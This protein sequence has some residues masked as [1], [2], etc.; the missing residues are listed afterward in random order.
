MRGTTLRES[1]IRILDRLHPKKIVIV[2]SAPQIRYPDYYGIDMSHLSE[3]IAFRAAIELRRDRGE[4]H[5]IKDVYDKCIAQRNLPKTSMKNYVK[6]IYEGFSDE[7]ISR[8]IVE[9]LRPS[10][11]NTD[12]EIV[13][14]TIDDLHRAI[15]NHTGDWYFS[16]DY[17]TPAGVKRV[18]EAFVEYAEEEFGW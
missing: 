11:V 6:E 14:Q 12:I 3:F 2:S 1:V 15:P 17:P 4:L 7:D 5:I 9:L 10:D 16:G 13:F 8:K 18:S